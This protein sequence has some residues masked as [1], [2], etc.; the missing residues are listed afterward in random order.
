MS[1]FWLTHLL[2][3]SCIAEDVLFSELFVYAQ[4]K[5]MKSIGY[6]KN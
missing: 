6:Q 2:D 3:G 4:N 5:H 1:A